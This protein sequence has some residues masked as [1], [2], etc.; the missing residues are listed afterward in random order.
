MIGTELQDIRQASKRSQTEFGALVGVHRT[1]VSDWETGKAPVPELVDAVV[2]MI[3]D[4]PEFLF[5]LERV[6]GLRK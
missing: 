1:T 2:R 6:R 3:R 5:R 4:E